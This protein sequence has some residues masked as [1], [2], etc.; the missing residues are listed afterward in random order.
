MSEM[1]EDALDKLVSDVRKTISDNERFLIAL[2]EENHD[3]AD[4]ADVALEES[5]EEFEEL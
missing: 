5:E 3:E 2:M 1:P 4:E